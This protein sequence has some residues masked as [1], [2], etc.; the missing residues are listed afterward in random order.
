MRYRRYRVG[1]DYKNI[2]VQYYL[3][4]WKMLEQNRNQLKPHEMECAKILFNSLPK[5]SKE[6]LTILKEK[7]YDSDN[8]S[9]F[10]CKRGIYTSHI[11][12]S[13]QVRAYQLN[14]EFEDYKK[15]RQVAEFELEKAML[16]VGKLVLKS[17]EKIYL[18]INQSLYI[19]S[20]DIQSVMYSDYSVSVGD[21]VL[22]HGIA[23]D[24]KQVF[25]TTNEVIKKGV[26]KLET[27]GFLREAL[28][29]YEL[30]EWQR[31]L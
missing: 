21:I 3:R 29:S 26:E 10:D 18:K 27:Y 11:P 12:I 15:Q 22:T 8:V 7:Y 6:S 16:E 30:E 24:D 17:E 5:V 28:N 14:I 1:R 23:C 2:R 31:A 13:D 9:N 20:V 19:K 25:D 4:R